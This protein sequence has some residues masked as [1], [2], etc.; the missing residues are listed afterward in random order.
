MS[1]MS[2]FNT[3]ILQYILLTIYKVKCFNYIEFEKSIIVLSFLFSLCKLQMLT[4]SFDVYL[5]VT[6]KWSAF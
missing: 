1:A 6:K 4:E 3:E 2:L 5:K